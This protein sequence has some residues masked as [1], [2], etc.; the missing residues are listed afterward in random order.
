L[1][2]KCRVIGDPFDP[3]RLAARWLVEHAATVALESGRLATS[4]DLPRGAC[5]I[6]AIDL[7]SLSRLKREDLR[8]HLAACSHVV[9]LNLSDTGLRE[10][11]LEF[12]QSMNSLRTLRLAKLSVSDQVFTWLEGHAG[13]EVLDL[14]ETSVTGLGLKKLA[15]AS[16]LKQLLL[17]NTQLNDAHLAALEQFP[18]LEDL[19]V[20][21]VGSLTDAGLVRISTLTNLRSLG[22]RQ[23]K[24]TDAGLKRLA[25]LTE[26]EKLELDRAKIGDDGVASLAVLKKL[27]HL[28]LNGT[29]VSDSSVST[30]SQMRQ[31]KTLSLS[32]TNV[33]PESIRLLQTELKGCS[34]TGSS[35]SP[36]DPGL[37]IEIGPFGVPAFNAGDGSGR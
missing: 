37:Q 1:G 28:G 33:T 36:R 19:D 20:S 25:K 35:A 22:L 27:R 13:L 21:T 16:G 12:L 23:A 34:V 11:D 4:Q 8:T 32:R 17:G 6:V 18:K 9:S 24:I 15:A 31:L 30:L 3:E 2:G 7:A 14:S 26:L 10:Q 5:R 29:Q